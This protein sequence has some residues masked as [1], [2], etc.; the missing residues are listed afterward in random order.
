MRKNHKKVSIRGVEFNLMTYTRSLEL[1]SRMNYETENLDFID[2]IN[3]NEVYFDVGA[4]EGRFA[5]YAVKKGAKVVAFEPESYNFRVLR[6]NIAINQMEESRLQTIH[7]GVGQKNGN[8]KIMIGQPWEGGHQKIIL[9]EYNRGD[10][11]FDFQQSEEVQIVSID[12]LVEAG[13]IPF[14]NYMKIDVDGSEMPFLLGAKKTLQNSKLK[15]IIFELSSSDHLFVEIISI[16]EKMGLKEVARYQIPNE[17]NLFNI[18]F[19]KVN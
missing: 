4:C 19:S 3:N 2:E 17:S 13:T 16:L 15:K 1:C 14:P 11:N 10:L 8:A 18:V 9:N 12:E 5:I 6:E 7:A